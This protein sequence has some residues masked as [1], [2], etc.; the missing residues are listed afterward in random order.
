MNSEHDTETKPDWKTN[1]IRIVQAGELDMNTTQTHGMTRAAALTHT[2]VG[3][4]HL[5]AGL[6]S[7]EPSTKTVAPHNSEQEPVIFVVSGRARYRWGNE[8]EYVVDADPGDFIYI[9]PYVPHQEINATTDTV[10][11]VV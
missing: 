3:I 2:R 5:W 11:E 9:P 7:V 10:A 4:N 1:G 8:L 6:V